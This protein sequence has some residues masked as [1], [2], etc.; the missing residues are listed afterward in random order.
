MPVLYVLTNGKRWTVPVLESKH[1]K[2]LN[3]YIKSI[4]GLCVKNR[5]IETGY[6]DRSYILPNGL[7]VWLELKREG[8]EPEPIQY[9]RLEQLSIRHQV[10]AWSDQYELSRSYFET[11]MDSARVS[12]E[13]HSTLIRTGIRWAIFRPRSREDLYLPSHIRDIEAARAGEARIDRSTLEALLPRL[14]L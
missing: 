2:D 9:Y 7:N 4:G 13:S 10:A 1:E 14:A 6:P 12:R 8:E 3:N 11:L 5:P